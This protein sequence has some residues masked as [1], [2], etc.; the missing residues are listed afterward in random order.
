MQASAANAF[1]LVIGHRAAAHFS[2]LVSVASL[3]FLRVLCVLPVLRV[4]S[5]ISASRANGERERE[6]RGRGEERQREALPILQLQLCVLRI[7]RALLCGAVRV[8]EQR[9]LLS[10]TGNMRSQRIG[11]ERDGMREDACRGVRE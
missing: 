9:S 8:A 5:H 6:R 4:C 7:G 11:I 2:L 3:P 10:C 1:G